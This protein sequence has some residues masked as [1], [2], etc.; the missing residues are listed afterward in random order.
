MCWFKDCEKINKLQEELESTKRMLVRSESRVDDWRNQWLQSRKEMSV[1]M[2]KPQWIAIEH[3]LPRDGQRVNILAFVGQYGVK[4]RTIAD[5]CSCK[6]FTHPFE[7]FYPD[8]KTMQV[9]YWSPIPEMTDEMKG[10]R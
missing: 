2:I 7:S 6:G 3:S 4:E 10:M 8:C 5:Y 1:M 9:M